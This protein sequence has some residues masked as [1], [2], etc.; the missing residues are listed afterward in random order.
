MP[1]FAGLL[2]KDPYWRLGGGLND[3]EEI[4]SHAFFSSINWLDL[5]K[6]NISP[7][8]KPELCSE[9]DTRYFD[10]KNTNASIKLT[11]SAQS[12]TG[13]EPYSITEGQ[14]IFA[15]FSFKENYSVTTPMSTPI[16]HCHTCSTS[17]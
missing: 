14:K 16:D 6:K 3:A 2:K 9:V 4:E 11:L 1:I 15:Q 12:L 17:L 5:I 10:N 13:I 7:P 8:F